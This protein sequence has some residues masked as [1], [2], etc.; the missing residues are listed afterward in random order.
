[1]E[2]EETIWALIQNSLTQLAAEKER[3]VRER[4]RER[5]R[6]REVLACGLDGEFLDMSFCPVAL[7]IP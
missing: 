2:A 1:M 7:E 6:G 4:V 3:K 5:E